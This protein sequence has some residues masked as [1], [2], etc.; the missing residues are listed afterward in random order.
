MPE[1]AQTRDK[2]GFWGSIGIPYYDL[3]GEKQLVIRLLSTENKTEHTD[4]SAAFLNLSAGAL[5]NAAQLVGTIYTT[6][7]HRMP[8]GSTM[9]SC[10]IFFLI[11]VICPHPIALQIIIMT[12]NQLVCQHPL[13]NPNYT[14]PGNPAHNFHF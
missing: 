9:Q 11:S 12:P 6:N 2:K 13:T 1:L 10:R 3:L 7:P 8:F 14:R 5:D 4:I